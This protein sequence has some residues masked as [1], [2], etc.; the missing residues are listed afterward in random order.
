MTS[1]I[2][3]F[4]QGCLLGIGAAIPI[5]P[6]NVAIARTVLCSGFGAGFLLGCG[7]VTI[8]VACAVLSSFSF[9]LISENSRFIPVLQIIGGA[10]LA[11]LGVICLISAWR[12]IDKNHPL[13]TAP[14]PAMHASYITGLLMTGTN[15]YTLLFW[16]VAVP[17]QVARM[18]SQTTH[19]LP[20]ICAGVFCAT[21]L[22]VICFAGALKWAGR[23]R[24]QV[25][26]LAADTVGG[27]MLLC[28]AV[29]G[30]WKG[31]RGFI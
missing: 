27:I 29:A 22:W 16:F 14:P 17:A 15:P 31:W 23:W 1:S 24:R 10:F 6:V 3:P 9:M 2:S 13:E 30:L 21:M 18:G 8:D 5:G 28:F 11:Y 25:W 4:L 26:M 20:M 12:A 19:R 7:A